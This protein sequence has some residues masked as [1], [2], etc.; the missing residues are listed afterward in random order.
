M[1]PNMFE[2]LIVWSTDLV[3]RISWISLAVF[4]RSIMVLKIVPLIK[5]LYYKFQISNPVQNCVSLGNAK[6]PSHR[7]ISTLPTATLSSCLTANLLPRQY[8]QASSLFITFCTRLNTHNEQDIRNTTH[9]HA[10][11]WHHCQIGECVPW[12]TCDNWVSTHEYL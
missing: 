4:L 1:Y 2:K 5:R 11:S 10:D 8:I 3:F 6:F 7:Q 12:C 9:N